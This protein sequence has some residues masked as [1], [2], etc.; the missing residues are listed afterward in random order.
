MGSVFLP[1]LRTGWHV[2]QAILAE[3]DRVV[4]LRF[5]RE[6]E[7]ACMIIDELLYSIADKVKNF[8]VIYLVN[9]DKVPDFNIMYELDQNKRE[10][11]TL[12]FFY[13]N[14]HILCDFGTGNNNKL[15][16]PIYDKQELI[17]I[18]ETIYRGARKGKGLVIS[19]KDYS[20][21]AKN[22]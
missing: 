18:I 15:N 5:G 1:N 11:Y 22:I 17:D 3:D 12:M 19:P 20:R 16:F 14:K 6:E 7:T 13:R 10:P 2:D 4:V 21:A 9:L 8:A